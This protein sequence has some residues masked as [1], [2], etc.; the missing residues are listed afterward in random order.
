[1]YYG[2]KRA[3]LLESCCV[4]N[5]VCKQIQHERG[6][7]MDK[8]QVFE[9]IFSAYQFGNLGFFAG[10]GLSKELTSGNYSVDQALDWESLLK[11]V[12]VCLELEDYN[13]KS[14]ISLPEHATKICHEYADKKKIPY[15]NAVQ[16][17]KE[18]VSSLCTWKLSD[19]KGDEYRA[20]MD[21]LTPSWII[22]TNFDLLLELVLRE[23]CFTL[24]P[25]D[26]LILQ[27]DRIPVYHLHGA[28]LDPESIVIN[29]EDY[30]KL[31]RPNEYRQIK[32]PLVF[33][34]STILFIGYGIGDIN[35]MTAIDWNNH[36]LIENSS[37]SYPSS[38]IQLLYKG[39][40]GDVKEPYELENGVIV[41][42][43][44]SIAD[45][46]KEYIEFHKEKL[47]ELE[48]EQQSV[49]LVNQMFWNADASEIERFIVDKGHRDQ[50]ID[51]VKQHGR[52]V[53]SSFIYFFSQ[54]MSEMSDRCM[55]NGA[56]EQY[57]IRLNIILDIICNF[58]LRDIH[59]SLMAIVGEHLGTVARFI[60]T[61]KGKSWEA[62]RTWKTRL[63]SIPDCM[64]N[65]LRSIAERNNEYSLKEILEY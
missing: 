26:P 49:S 63:G 65:E 46:F 47:V 1:M 10:A 45:F 50:T 37:V 14:T 43:I 13:F 64:I 48:S 38:K 17:F 58:K 3:C 30:V 44:H 4:E 2:W 8:T 6:Y 60:G 18:K 29:Q 51:V 53:L 36:V 34:E 11:K 42:E 31:F 61:D 7:E 62:H 15:S 22:T 21:V 28:R 20:Y 40:D 19:G 33:K 25:E 57:E 5:G 24:Y 9:E 39:T 32:M 16:V 41:V 27:K 55:E 54:V 56:F 52:T 12:C 35:I 23:R 59:P